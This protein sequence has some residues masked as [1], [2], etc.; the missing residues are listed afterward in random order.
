[1]K[2]PAEGRA[3]PP[4]E[5]LLRAPA[6]KAL[7]SA[8]LRVLSAEALVLFPAA[9]VPLLSRAAVL[10]S[11]DGLVLAE[12]LVLLVLL[13]PPVAPVLSSADQLAS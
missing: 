12:L 4:A 10:L 8:E 6:D 9:L 5:L 7:L 3:L 11:V 1:M 13:A 2:S